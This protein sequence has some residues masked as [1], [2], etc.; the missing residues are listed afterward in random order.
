MILASE[1]MWPT[2]PQET[3]AL[4]GELPSSLPEPTQVDGKAK[5]TRL[6]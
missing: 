1:C 3:W 4:D 6:R 2:S 5:I